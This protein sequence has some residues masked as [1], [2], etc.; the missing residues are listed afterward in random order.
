VL[1]EEW[2][3]SDSISSSGIFDIMQAVK[4]EIT[5]EKTDCYKDV[6]T[7]DGKQESMTGNGSGKLELGL[8]ASQSIVNVNVVKNENNYLEFG[9]NLIDDQV[10]Q[11][12]LTKEEVKEEF[13]EDTNKIKKVKKR[14]GQYKK[15]PHC[16]KQF[17]DSAKL[18]YHV[19]THT[20]EKPFVCGVCQQCFNHPSH[21]KRHMN[22][23]K[24]KI[25]ACHHCPKMFSDKKLLQIHLKDID[26][27]F[28][29]DIC[30]SVFARK[31]N[32]LVHLRKHT[33]ETPYAC[34]DCG[35]TFNMSYKLKNHITKHLNV[36]K[37]R[38]VCEFCG[39]EYAKK[40][41]LNEHS[42]THSGEPAVKCDQCDQT[43]NTRAAYSQHMNVHNKKH[44]CQECEKCFGNQRNLERHE[45]MHNGVKDFQCAC[46][47]KSYTS[48]RSLQKHME[49]KHKVTDG[50]KQAFSCDQCD[51]SYTRDEY[52][53]RHRK[54]H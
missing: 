12:E 1:H 53:Q 10:K 38:F 19:Y 34:S 8:E 43:F 25:L 14:T 42:R 32:L 40:A 35:E 30:G 26:K 5:D 24:E 45:K 36:L 27:S 16:E 31:E 47:A 17:N 54:K 49:I 46:C 52:L 33:G 29:C 39:K 13:Q 44:E 6:E 48:L 22:Q 20:G 15:C 51:R 7:S 4:V 23:H 37:Q 41:G 21:F 50:K 3:E 11:N 18:R 28:T 2:G 9:K